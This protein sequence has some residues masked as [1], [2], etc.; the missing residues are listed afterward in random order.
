MI[1]FCSRGRLFNS[2]ALTDG[3]RAIAITEEKAA[4]LKRQ[5]NLP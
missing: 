3:K 1:R 2:L 5:F 4:A